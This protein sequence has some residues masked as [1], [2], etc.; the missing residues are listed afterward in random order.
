VSAQVIA[1]S[2]HEWDTSLTLGVSC[3]DCKTEWGWI[4]DMPGAYELLQGMAE[5]HNEAAHPK[6]DQ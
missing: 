6:E 5:A 1:Y 4:Y 3:S 2:A